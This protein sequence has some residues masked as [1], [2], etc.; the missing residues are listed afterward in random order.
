LGEPVVHVL[1]LNL[2]LD[3]RFGDGSTHSGDGR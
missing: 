2:D 3:A 1:E